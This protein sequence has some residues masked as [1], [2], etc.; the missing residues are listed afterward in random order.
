MTGTSSGNLRYDIDHAVCIER[1][2]VSETDEKKIWR[3]GDGAPSDERPAKKARIP[4]KLIRFEDTFG[5][6]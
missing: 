3:C 5:N 2:P 1:C 4:R 6:M